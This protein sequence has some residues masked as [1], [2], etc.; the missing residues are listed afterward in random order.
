M[1]TAPKYVV[2][3][4]KPE[5]RRRWWKVGTKKIKI[6][7]PD[8]QVELY[9]L[10][11][12]KDGSNQLSRVRSISDARLRSLG[13][14]DALIVVRKSSHPMQLSFPRV[15]T[16]Q[17]SH[18]YD[19]L[20]SGTWWVEDAQRMLESWALRLVVPEAPLSTE[21][22]QSWIN[23][24][25]SGHVRE[26]IAQYSMEQL[27][28]RNA[29]PLGWWRAQAKKWLS[30]Y[31]LSVRINDVRFES[32]EA[33]R[34]KAEQRRIEDLARIA[35]QQKRERQAELKSLAALED[36]KRQRAT[37]ESNTALAAKERKHRLELLEMQ[38]RKELLEAEREIE[39]ARRAAERAALEHEVAMAKLRGNLRQAQL[40]EEQANAADK[41]HQQ[42]L[43]QLEA[44]RK[45]LEELPKRLLTMLTMLADADPAV[46]HQAAERLVSPEF[47]VAPHYLATLGYPV[48]PQSAVGYLREKAYRDCQKV[49]LRKSDLRT[50]NIGTRKVKGLPL[51]TSLQFTVS[52]SRPGFVTLLNIGTSGD[53]FIQ[54]PNAYCPPRKARIEAGVEYSIPGSAL[55][56]WEEL[57]SRGLDYV[58]IGPP[59][60]EHVVAIVSDEPLIGNEIVQRSR[61]EEPFVKLSADEFDAIGE[62]LT[63]WDP[64]KWSV[65]LL[66]F[67]V[68]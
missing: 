51:N 20:V 3:V 8:Y 30:E 61:L 29:L 4:L 68:E 9:Y 10:T 23:K 17:R 15:T 43:H 64:G 35:A 14:E 36:Y 26:V 65:G 60:W 11:I 46:R 52:S 27:L 13:L 1:S 48:T 45:F 19:L 6:P 67:L 66:S 28:V 50:R 38:Y 57:R 63:S 58:E 7:T 47:S 54:V 44:A 33:A 55:L 39:D 32:A 25:L 16:D 18:H 49:V 40:A 31:G 62:R 42:V 41:E 22:T 59:G 24:L 53:V 34:E 37:I 12:A 2:E 56:P 5:S 21:V